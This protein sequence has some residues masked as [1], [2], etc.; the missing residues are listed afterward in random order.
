[1]I[2]ISEILLYWVIIVEDSHETLMDIAMSFTDGG[3]ATKDSK[4]RTFLI[5]GSGSLR[6]CAGDCPLESLMHVDIS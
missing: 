3:I 2:K 6:F 4:A 5:K 1:L